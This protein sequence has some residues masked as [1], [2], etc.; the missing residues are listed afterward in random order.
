MTTIKAAQ[1]LLPTC[2]ARYA[3][4]LRS[5]FFGGPRWVV[6]MNGYDIVETCASVADASFRA[7]ALNYQRGCIAVYGPIGLD[8]LP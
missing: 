6:L 8:G 1:D 2:P 5:G 4:D 3:A 7:A